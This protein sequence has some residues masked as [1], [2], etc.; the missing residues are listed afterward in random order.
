[1]TKALYLLKGRVCACACVCVRVGAWVP[2]NLWVLW[3]FCFYTL[4]YTKHPGIACLTEAYVT[5]GKIARV[6]CRETYFWAEVLALVHPAFA[7][8]GSYTC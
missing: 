8:A 4:W 2:S 5:W 6:D 7:V 3:F 1:M